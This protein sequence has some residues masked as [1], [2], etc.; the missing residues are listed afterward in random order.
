LT[1]PGRRYRKQ[2]WTK[3]NSGQKIILRIDDRLETALASAENQADGNLTG[4]WR[5]LVDVLS[6]TAENADLRNVAEGLSIVHRMSP[7]VAVGERASGIRALTGRLKSP[8]L[9]QLFV[10]DVPEIAAAAISAAQLSDEDWSELVPELPV[11]ARGFLR[12]RTDLGPKT[13]RALQ[14]W[15][16]ADFRLSGN[17]AD[18]VVPITESVGLENDDKPAEPQSQIGALVQRI[19]E[20]RR[21]R[22]NLDSPRLPLGDEDPASEVVEIAEIQFETDDNGTIVWVEGAPRGAIVGTDI[23]RASFDDGPGPDAY[24]AAAF[25]QRMPM[26]SARMVLRG[27][28]SIDGDWRMSAAPFFDQLTGR[29]RGFRGLMRRPNIAEKAHDEGDDHRA[30]RLQAENMQQIVHELRTPL[31]AIAGFAEIIEQQLFGPVADDYRGMASAI[32]DDARRLLS[33]LEDMSTAARLDAGNLEIQEGATECEWLAERLAER[34]APISDDL[35]VMVNISLAGPV[36]P[37]A[38]DRDMAERI[39]SRLLSALIICGG[40]GEVL[41]GRFRTELGRT[42]I[43][44]F[45]LDLPEKLTDSS[46]EDL[47][48]SIPAIDEPMADKAASPLLGLGFS[49]RLVRNLARKVGGDLRFQ[50]ESLLLILPTIQNYDVT[51]R[52]IGGD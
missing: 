9:I 48:G 40:K 12:A 8:P 17:I 26:G 50:K 46:E 35:G 29:F 24:G 10:R 41:R 22:E 18:H 6:Q 42:A 2:Q 45:R 13:L 44:S 38:I 23:A 34:L 21:N 19:E 39:F 31:G 7:Q 27:A 49:L 15:A 36:R 14:N 47:L 25:R 43:N 16:G 5:Q 3:I 4:I 1:A 51:V 37:F 20:W 28:P 32:L 52:D 33:G 11:R 30:R